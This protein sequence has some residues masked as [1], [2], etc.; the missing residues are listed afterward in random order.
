VN[1][2][3]VLVRFAVGD[4]NELAVVQVVREIGHRG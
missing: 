3:N 2:A 1:A 4:E